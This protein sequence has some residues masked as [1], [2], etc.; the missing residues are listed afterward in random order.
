MNNNHY[1]NGIDA[2]RI[3]AGDLVGPAVVTA[4]FQVSAR[5]IDQS[6][7]QRGSYTMASGV[8][9]VTFPQAYATTTQLVV[10]VT[11]TTNPSVDHYLQGVVVSGFTISGSGTETGNWMSM[12]Y[13]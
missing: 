7:V 2:P 1:H 5:Q 12:G 3:D 4:N 10:V 9:F 13:R 6:V 8:V 11:P